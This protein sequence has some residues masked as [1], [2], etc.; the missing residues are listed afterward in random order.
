MESDNT[1][2]LDNTAWHALGTEHAKFAR[3]TPLARRY[4]GDIAPIAGC[5][6]HS[7]D[8]MRQLHSLLEPGESVFLP[9][10]AT[11]LALTAGC[12]GLRLIERLD[13]LQMVA[14]R[15]TEAPEA[16]GSEIEQLGDEHASQMVELTNVAFPTFFRARTWAI[17][18]YWGIRVRGEL[19]AMAGERLALPG[20]REISGVCTRPGH[21][22]RGYAA[23]LMVHLMREHARL[24]LNS[25]LHVSLE[26][27]RAIALYR[28][29][30]FEVRKQLAVP[31]IERE[32]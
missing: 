23:Q 29:L 24:G 15:T 7:D 8:S 25:F 14:P 27:D 26:N 9:G 17:G 10:D 22:G 18:N 30:G 6:D 19:V 11:R 2:P 31:H 1:H 28:R 32:R 21:T 4:P 13:V 12:E 20:Y 3:S 5:A 16:N